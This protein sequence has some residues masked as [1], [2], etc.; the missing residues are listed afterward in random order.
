[1]KHFNALMVTGLLLLTTPALAANFTLHGAVKNETAYFISGEQRLDKMQNR[2]DLKPEAVLSNHWEFRGRFLGWYDASSDF[3]GSNNT[4]LTPVIQD[5]YRTYSEVKEAYLLYAADDFD[6][7]LGQQQ[8]IWGKTDGLR[9]LDIV[10]P[11]DM[12]EFLLDDFLDSRMG[13]VAAR[14]NFYSYLG[15][16]EH[17]FEFLVIPD[18]QVAKFAP[19]GSRWASS[20]PT[21]PNV[22]PV[23]QQ[24]NVPNW[25]PKNTE[26]GIAWRANVDGWDLSLNWFYGWKDTPVLDKKITNGTLFVTPTYKQMHTFG[27]S[28]SNAFGAYVL[29]GELAV[30]IN[31]GINTISSIRET[32]T[33][34][35]AV[36][37]DYNQNNWRISPQIF[38][39]HLRGWDNAMLEDQNSGFVSLM[40]STDYMNDKLKPETIILLNW[41][42]GSWMLRPKVSYEFSDQITAKLGLDMF[43]G[44]KNDFFGQFDKNDRIYSEIE[45]TF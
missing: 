10:N 1:M 25:S 5:Y 34:N 23:I 14:M 11:L 24:S 32:N 8:I 21:P 3:L 22:I 16:R 38:I 31:E 28:F 33:W 2:L 41:A 37:L 19:Q 27:G 30:N 35:A 42:D 36:G 20:I 12:R 6:L 7:R 40:V 17:E 43:G 44:D 15:G 45:Y 4:D 18:A 39:R 9:L 29:R 13:V 26:Y